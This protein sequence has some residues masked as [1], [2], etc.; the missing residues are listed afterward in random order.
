MTL[1][2][3]SVKENAH[4]PSPWWR[5]RSP[6]ATLSN[7]WLLIT[8][9]LFLDPLLAQYS[10]H[11]VPAELALRIA[12]LC[13]AIT[14]PFLNQA[15]MC[16]LLA[17]LRLHNKKHLESRSRLISGLVLGGLCL[18]CG[19]KLALLPRIDN[20]VGLLFLLCIALGALKTF[21]QARK[22]EKPSVE[23]SP[24]TPLVHIEQWQT[25]LIIIF[26]L[27]ALTARAV[28]MVMSMADYSHDRIVWCA[29]GMLMSA[30]LL[31]MLKPKKEYFVGVCQRCKHPVPIVFVEF[32]SCPLCDEK[33]RNQAPTT[34]RF[35][36]KPTKEA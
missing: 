21:R 31:A 19:I 9:S 30:L 23:E 27:P 26:A 25:Q 4:P 14:L 7:L 8:A 12:M 22:A 6:F 29:A 28:S 10:S 1:L 17:R 18:T 15:G 33:L 34:S 11:S 32:G 3:K 35:S 16:R 36:A 20:V 2:R 13:A 24:A 5:G